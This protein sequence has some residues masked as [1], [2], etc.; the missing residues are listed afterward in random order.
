MT[1]KTARNLLITTLLMGAAPAFADSTVTSPD[2]STA[3]VPDGGV[4]IEPG[5][6]IVIDPG[7]GVAVTEFAPVNVGLEGVVAWGTTT[8]GPAWVDVRGMALYNYDQDTPGK[9]NCNG[10]CVAS[11]PTLAA[12]SG[13]VGVDEWTVITRDDGSHQWAFRGHPLYTF[14]KDTVPGE[15]NGDG[16]AGFHLAD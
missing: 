4:V 9:S 6:T 1:F 5:S 12:K 8:K 10:D 13:D 2:G 14:V 7:S 3:T 15:V 11:W 16:A